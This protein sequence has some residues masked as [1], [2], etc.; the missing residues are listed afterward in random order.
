MYPLSK[1]CIASTLTEQKWK[2]LCQ[3]KPDGNIKNESVDVV[4]VI[5]TSR[6]MKGEKLNNIKKGIQYLLNNLNQND[7]LSLIQFNQVSKR[8]T[9]LIKMTQS[10][11]DKI[12]S[13][14]NKVNCEKITNT[15]SGLITAS[16]VIHSRRYTSSKP[17]VM[18]FSDGANRAAISNC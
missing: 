18:L 3:I 8:L 1:K 2:I 13:A 16:Q 9:P 15:S 7:R 6:S 4:A 11:K 14:L 17:C 5:D 10:G 12:L